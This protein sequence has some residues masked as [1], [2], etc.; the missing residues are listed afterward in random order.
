M[1]ACNATQGR[2]LIS[3][4]K[5]QPMTYMEMLRLGLSVCPWKRVA[6]SLKPSERIKKGRDKRNRITWRVIGA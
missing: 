6:E 3:R 2:E 5:R 4:L 1:K